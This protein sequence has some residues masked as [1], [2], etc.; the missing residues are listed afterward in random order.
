MN[1]KPIFYFQKEVLGMAK[2]RNE[3]A[4]DKPK[5]CLGCYIARELYADLAEVAKKRDVSLTFVVK[6]AL[7]EYISKN[8]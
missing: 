6:E 1:G 2:E 5:R 7:K 4:A 3:V 8:K